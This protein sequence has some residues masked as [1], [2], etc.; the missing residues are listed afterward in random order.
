MAYIQQRGQFWRVE[1]R[2]KGYKPTYRTFRYPE[3]G[4]TVGTPR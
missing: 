3:T 1:V 4:S 2:R